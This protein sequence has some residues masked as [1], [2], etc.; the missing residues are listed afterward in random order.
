MAT[1]TTKIMMATATTTKKIQ[2]PVKRLKDFEIY[3]IGL[4][5]AVL[6]R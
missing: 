4:F 6:I 3:M 1:A 2:S 5:C